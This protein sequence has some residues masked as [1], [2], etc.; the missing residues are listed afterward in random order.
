MARLRCF[1][2]LLMFAVLGTITTRADDQEGK[3]ICSDVFKESPGA[4]L[5]P[6]SFDNG[7][8]YAAHLGEVSDA[9]TCLKACCDSTQC[10]LVL[11]DR[12]GEKIQCHLVNCVAEGTGLDACITT[13][14]AAFDSYRKRESANRSSS[15]DQE[16]CHAPIKVGPCRAAFPRFNYDPVNQ[17]CRE[18]IYGGCEA[19]ANNYDSREECERA[20]A[21]VK[22]DETS[23]YD[24]PLVSKRMSGPVKFEVPTRDTGLI[25]EYRDSCEVAPVVGPCRASMRR[26]F[27]N[28]TSGSCQLFVYGGCRGN[29]NNYKTQAECQA[30]CSEN[31]LP[32]HMPAM[33]HAAPKYE[34]H[35]LAQVEVGPCRAAFRSW[36]YDSATQDCL[37]FIYGGCRGNLNR[38]SSAQDC[39]SRCAGGPEAHGDNE[40][41][42]NGF[43]NHHRRAAFVLT[44]VL[45]VMT[46][47]LVMGLIVVSLRKTRERQL[48]VID[49]KEELLPSFRSEKA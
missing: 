9:Q 21:G 41:Q 18:F 31:R 22:A 40:H 28:A 27:Y 38:Y 25:K 24:I 42:D 49:D 48:L 4:G 35:C 3:D 17:T 37:P 32:V 36:Y 1:S 14:D 45:A 19:N 13:P 10:N 43:L 33:K 23:L 44:A 2:F 47:L 30:K 5:D 11:V 26:F 6:K 16:R 39:M 7:A 20:C 12:S 46:V 15:D 8:A 34:D 29:D